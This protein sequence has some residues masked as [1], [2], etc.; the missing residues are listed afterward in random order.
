[1]ISGFVL[2][3]LLAAPAAA[4]E[5]PLEPLTSTETAT[6]VA[7]AKEAKSLPAGTLFLSVALKEPPKA[8]VLAWRLGAPFRREAALVV[9]DRKTKSLAEAVVDLKT[10]ALTLW[11]PRPGFQPGPRAAPST[12]Q[13]LYSAAGSTSV[14]SGFALDGHEVRW[15]NFI[16]H[17]ALHPRE[18]PVL[19]EVSYQDGAKLRPILYRASL[20][21]IL[22]P[23]GF[24]ESEYGLGRMA[25]ALD[26][27]TAAPAGATFIDADFA[28]S[29]RHPYTLGRAMALYERG[30]KRR[31]RELVLTSRATI[32][33]EGYLISWIFRQ[34]GT[35][36]LETALTDGKPAIGGAGRI[37]QTFFNAR[38]DFDVD[39]AENFVWE[40]NLR[41]APGGAGHSS[42]IAV[43]ST[44]LAREKSAQRDLNFASARRWRI[45]SAS[46]KNEFGTPTGYA[47]IPDG[48]AAP[49]LRSSSAL[50][51]R[52][53]FVDHH[54][55]VTRY[56]DEE[57]DAAGPYPDQGAPGQGLSAW[58]KADRDLKGKDVVVWYTFGVTRIA[59]PEDWPASAPAKAG[60]ELIPI[61]FFSKNPAP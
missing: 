49:Y 60:F 52:G 10:K 24:A 45:V 38:L 25:V 37:R 9:F 29:Y 5:H 19:Y 57:L 54:L 13:G 58:T 33:D 8:E 21:E 2:A 28:D 39:G 32:G 1:M 53:R 36:S 55:W 18:G 34:D 42:E 61:G 50:R 27:G 14:V 22:T 20:S 15:G 17:F 48:N 46:V 6:A 16:F 23:E 31:A 3:A 35:I 30:G 12:A 47:L 40:D 4:S 44:P 41:A 26:S 56:S 11:V 51:R 7:V 59:R 43:K